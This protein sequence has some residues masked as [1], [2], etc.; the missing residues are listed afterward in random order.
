MNKPELL[1][2]IRI[3]EIRPTNAIMEQGQ[4]WVPLS[5]RPDLTPVQ[6]LNGG[7]KARETPG[8]KSFLHTDITKYI[9]FALLIAGGFLLAG[10]ALGY[11]SPTGGTIGLALALVGIVVRLMAPKE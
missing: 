4:D 11:T 5:S 7:P 10:L 3:G 8:T 9:G 2:K 1:A 6:I